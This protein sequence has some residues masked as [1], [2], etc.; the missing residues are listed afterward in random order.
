MK[1]DCEIL[2]G[3]ALPEQFPAGYSLRQLTGDAS[4]RSY[5]RIQRPSGDTLVLMKMPDAFEEER[6]PYLENY[7]LF[8]RLG[9]R[10][11]EIY[12]TEPARAA[13]G[14]GGPQDGFRLRVIIR[15]GEQTDAVT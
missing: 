12:H 2:A 8:R 10:L 5:F 1:Q 3:W 13:P 4:T 9:I 14:L 6:F 15:Y 7:H 11:A